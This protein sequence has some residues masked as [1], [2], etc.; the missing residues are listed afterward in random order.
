MVPAP[1]TNLV[2]TF[3]GLELLVSDVHLLGTERAGAV[4]IVAH[5]HH[6]RW[7]R[8][9]GARGETLEGG[10]TGGGC[11]GGGGA[12]IESSERG[13][14]GGQGEGGGIGG[15]RWVVDWGRK[16]WTFGGG[17]GELS[18]CVCARSAR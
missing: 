12:L 3:A 4:S 18:R 10:L 8:L 5:R 15:G 13:R 16:G 6:W 2:A 11:G 1:D 14:Q 7:I 9:G 17:R